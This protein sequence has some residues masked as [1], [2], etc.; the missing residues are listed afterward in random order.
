LTFQ[1]WVYYDSF[2]FWSR[3][4]E[5]G[6]GQPNQNVLFANDGRTNNLAF[7]VYHDD[8]S[9]GKV[10]A[11]DILETGKWLHLAAV[12]DQNGYVK[13]FKNGEVVVVGIT[14]VPQNVNR[15]QNYIAR[16]NWDCDEYFSGKIDEVKVYA[17]ILSDEEIR[18]EFI[19][20]VV[21]GDANNNGEIT[22]ADV[23][24]LVNYVLKNGPSPIPFEAGDVNCDENVDI[25]DAVYLVNYLFK[26]GPPPC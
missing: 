15:V 8:S 20:G 17:R 3:I 25:I 2:N 14:A 23:V 7:E 6:N 13:I 26:D 1:A 10:I 19:K 22:I 21:R 18:E 5:F 4:I 16:S 12:E 9:G 11:N 24:Y